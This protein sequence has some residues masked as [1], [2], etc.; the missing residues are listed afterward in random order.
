MA[1]FGMVVRNA[2]AF[3][4][5]EWSFGSTKSSLLKDEMVEC[6]GV[7]VAVDTKF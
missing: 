7:Y 3:Q 5:A 4:R 2:A 6:A 1:V